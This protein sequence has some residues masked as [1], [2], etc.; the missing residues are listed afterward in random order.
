MKSQSQYS[1][2]SIS[3]SSGW[4]SVAAIK[5]LTKSSLGGKGFFYLTGCSLTSREVRAGTQD[6]HLEAGAEGHGQVRLPDLFLMACSACFLIQFK[7]SCPGVAPSTVEW[8]LPHQSFHHEID[9]QKYLWAS[10]LE[11][12]SQMKFFF[13][14]NPGLCEVDKK[15]NGK[16]KKKKHVSS[17]PTQLQKGGRTKPK[18]RA[19][20]LRTPPHLFSLPS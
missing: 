10:L 9:L 19:L 13:P 14:V 5:A 15:Q 20:L 4:P 2:L 17:F 1:P 3:F 18:E 6:R 12:F 8:I 7:T 16:K 11:A